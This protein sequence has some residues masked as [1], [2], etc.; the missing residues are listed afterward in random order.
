MELK[1]DYLLSIITVVYNGALV[2][3]KTIESLKKQD[4]NLFEYIVID[5]GSTDGTLNILTK[6]QDIIDQQISE[7]DEGIYDA[8]N[9]GVQLAKGKSLLFLNAGDY[10]IG[11]VIN[12]LNFTYPSLI[13]VK[14]RTKFGRL[15]NFKRRN[16]KFS[17]PYCHQGMIFENHKLLYNLRYQI[18]ADYDYYLRHNYT[19]LKFI[20]THGYVMYDNEGVST[21]EYLKKYQEIGKIIKENFPLFNY[22]TYK[23]RST[24]KHYIKTILKIFIK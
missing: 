16:Y 17:H 10:F 24:I 4:R 5:G 7:E 3:E 20:K 13:P 14:Y 2:I 6:Y 22:Y 1:K 12:K 18:A 15:I 9:K 19:K 11:N 23:I 8:M 21:I